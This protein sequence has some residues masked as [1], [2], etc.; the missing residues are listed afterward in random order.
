[1]QICGSSRWEPE[2]FLKHFLNVSDPER[3]LNKQKILFSMSVCV[4]NSCL[5]GPPFAPLLLTKKNKL[6][7][8]IEIKS[9]TITQL[10][11]GTSEIRLSSPAFFCSVLI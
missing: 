5:S 7:L 9:T 11:K 4:P 10:L 3:L 2:C 8:N 1:M 6:S